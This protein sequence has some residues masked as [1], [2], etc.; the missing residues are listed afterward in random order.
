M[1]IFLPLF[2]PGLVRESRFHARM[3]IVNNR[4][5][6][7]STLIAAFP[8]VLATGI[9][10]IPV[11]S[12]YSDHNLAQEAAGQSVRWFLGHIHS[13]AAF[14]IG[15]LACCC[16][17]DV[18][19]RRGQRNRVIFALPFIA[20]GAGLHAAGLGAD[21]IGPL[22]VTEAGHPAQ[23]FFDGSGTLVPGVF[24]AGSVTFGL[25]LIAL[26]FGIARTDLLKSP[27]RIIVPVAAVL[28][29][30]FEALPTGWGLYP[31]ALSCF[32]IF[33]P[34]SLALRKSPGI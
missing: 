2:L 28:F 12:D 29:V 10:L 19:Y 16:I 25:G 33:A 3:K 4:S 15:V 34:V 18:L 6:L 26:A 22:A 23:A 5:R 7:Y 14:G 24:V 1:R 13:A 27:W 17:G 31:V 9:V 21:G 20:V 30:A 11:V 8:I 32:L